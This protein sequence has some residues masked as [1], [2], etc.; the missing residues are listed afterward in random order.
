MTDT[1]EGNIRLKKLLRE[2][3]VEELADGS[4]RVKGPRPIWWPVVIYLLVVLGLV[5]SSV[6]LDGIISEEL[7]FLMLYAGSA[8]AGAQL[9]LVLISL[10]AG[11]TMWLTLSPR[12]LLAATVH[13][14]VEHGVRRIPWDEIL[15]VRLTTE[16]FGLDLRFELAGEQE[17]AIPGDHLAPPPLEVWEWVLE[18]AP[19]PERVREAFSAEVVRVG[20]IVQL[21]NEA[22][23]LSTPPEGSWL[24]ENELHRVRV[25]THGAG[26]ALGVGALVLA[27]VMV[28]PGVVMLTSIDAGEQ[29]VG[30][31]LTAVGLGVVGLM[32]LAVAVRRE[33]I[34]ATPRSLRV[35]HRG[36]LGDRV[37]DVDERPE[38]IARPLNAWLRVFLP[39]LVVEHRGRRLRMGYVLEPAQRWWLLT[40]LRALWNL[41]V[42]AGAE[43]FPR[44]ER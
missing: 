39:H 33:D 29:W 11:G 16:A 8:A 13:L 21:D 4:V 31:I 44:D 1:S 7:A 24:L 34:I 42:P 25:R 22:V 2:W 35:I 14:Q 41:S 40:R 12:G 23:T 18:R 38:A 9:V 30:R 26:T 27:L 10:V 5:V 3:R 15:G 17:W 28:F 32:M 6:L 37:V 36:I 43:D 20:R 19:L